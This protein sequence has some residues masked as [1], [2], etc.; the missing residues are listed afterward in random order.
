MPCV[1]GYRR[2]SEPR[3]IRREIK[4]THASLSRSSGLKELR[5]GLADQI[6]LLEET[7]SPFAVRRAEDDEYDREDR[8]GFMNEERK[9]AGGRSGSCLN[10]MSELLEKP[11]YPVAIV[12]WID[13]EEN[14]R[15]DSGDTAERWYS[16]QKG[17]WAGGL[18]SSAE[19]GDPDG[20]KE[21]ER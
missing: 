19:V 14:H 2:K 13:R 6:S 12:R 8:R 7:E 3:R 9:S 16:R 4:D 20:Q 18:S 11:P 5:F 10:A 15:V 17:V 1:S 21:Y